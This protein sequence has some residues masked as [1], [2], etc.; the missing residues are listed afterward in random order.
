ML[1]GKV[2]QTD[3]I[4]RFQAIIHPVQVFSIPDASQPF[5][6]LLPDRVGGIRQHTVLK[7][8]LLRVLNL[9]QEFFTGVC[10]LAQH[11]KVNHF[12][13]DYQAVFFLVGEGDAGNV[14]AWNEQFKDLDEQLL[15]LRGAENDFESG[16]K[17]QEGIPSLAD[18]C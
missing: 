5:G 12:F 15:V 4:D 16:I 11:V 8:V 6:Q 2:N 17:Q 7:T 18:G 13:R 3:D 1:Q 9:Y 14:F 10:I